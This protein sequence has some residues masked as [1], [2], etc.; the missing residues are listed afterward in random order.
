MVDLLARRQ[1]DAEA[2]A[3]TVDDIN[4]PNGASAGAISIDPG[5]N[6]AC[7][8]DSVRGSIYVLDVNPDSASYNVVVQTI[9]VDAKS[10]LRQIAIS[11]DGHKLFATAADGYI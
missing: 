1:V 5:D 3:P 8:T 4:L 7:V 2:S 9:S 6:Y 10:G 11:S